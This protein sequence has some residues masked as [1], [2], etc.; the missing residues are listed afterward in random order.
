MKRGLILYV[1][2]G[3]EEFE[4]QDTQD[5]SASLGV[6]GASAVCA[7]TTEEEIV[8]NWWRL[9]TRGMHEVLCM[10]AAYDAGCNRLEPH[11]IPLRLY[12]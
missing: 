5:W 6:S 1:T 10:H 9:F 8:Y 11:G 2:E 4:M 7:A 12:G 3:K